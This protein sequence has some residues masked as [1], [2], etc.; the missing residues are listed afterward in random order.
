MDRGCSAGAGAERGST[1]RVQLSP[2][3]ARGCRLLGCDGAMGAT[4]VPRGNSP[5]AAG[6]SCLA[7]L[8]TTLDGQRPRRGHA[9]GRGATASG[10]GRT[11]RSR[12]RQHCGPPW[13]TGG[14]AA[15]RCNRRARI[16]AERGGG[17]GG[18]SSPPVVVPSCVTDAN[19]PGGCRTRRCRAR[20]APR[21]RLQPASGLPG[22]GVA[23]PGDRGARRP[24]RQ[25]R[26]G[27]ATLRAFTIPL[28]PS[29]STSP[30]KGSTRNGSGRTEGC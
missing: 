18:R 24:R 7:P 16:A 2:S 19:L 14:L 3:A 22:A 15:E 30:G 9:R 5:A 8:G 20:S 23:Y 10:L 12:R 28:L 21:G 27:R 29:A 4:A 6:C 1:P 26:R 13:P 11:L 25:W 17:S